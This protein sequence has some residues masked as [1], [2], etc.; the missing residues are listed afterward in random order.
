ME[1]KIF[2]IDMD[3]FFASVEEM[4][5]NKKIPLIVSNSNPKSVILASNYLAKKYGINSGMPV[6]LAQ[7]KKHDILICKPHLADYQRISIAIE[8][9]LFQYSKNVINHSIDEWSIDFS[10]S[11]LIYK[12]EYE[13]AS[14]IQNHIK[15]EF[16]ITCSIGISFNAFFAKMA[17]QFNKPNNIEIISKENFKEKLWNLDIEEMYLVGKKSYKLMKELGINT[18]GN[19]ANYH[20]PRKLK[21]VF[22]ISGIKLYEYAN[23]VVNKYNENHSHSISVSRTFYHELDSY[24]E[25]QIAFKRILNEVLYRMNEENFLART[26][27]VAINYLNSSKSKSHSF[28][29]YIN[30]K[31]EIIFRAQE[32]LDEFKKH[33]EIRKISVGFANIIYPHENNIQL[34]LFNEHF[35]NNLVDEINSSFQKNVIDYA[36]KKLK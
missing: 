12:N 26:V 21:E 34:K 7:Q 3:S 19:L 31:N 30:N 4:K 8:N 18:I 24:E 13:L 16:K 5:L 35:N 29:D 9:A 10:D 15:K 22:G 33:Q 2:Y 14:R 1:N 36:I 17:S 32:L 23:G 6:F 20:N 25:M 27:T 11:K 28:D